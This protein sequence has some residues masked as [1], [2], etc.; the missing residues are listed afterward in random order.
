MLPPLNMMMTSVKPASANRAP[1]RRSRWVLAGRDLDRAADLVGVAA[2]RR[3]RLV[4]LLRCRDGAF[5]ITAG[6]AAGVPDVGVPSGQLEHCRATGPTQIGGY[7][8]WTGLGFATAL[9]ILK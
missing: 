5:N 1:A 3:A 4:E 7:G 6:V 8:F 2:D 9:L